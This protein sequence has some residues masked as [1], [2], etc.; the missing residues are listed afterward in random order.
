[1][2]VQTNT[3][4]RSMLE[5][6]MRLVELKKVSEKSLNDRYCMFEGRLINL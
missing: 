4:D 2:T 5:N 1:M 6:D 3:I